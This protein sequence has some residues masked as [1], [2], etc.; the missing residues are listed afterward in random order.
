MVADE[1][2]I[3]NLDKR[4]V[5][6]EEEYGLDAALL[7]VSKRSGIL[8]GGEKSAMPVRGHEHMTWLVEDYLAVLCHP[9]P[10]SLLEEEDV[11]AVK[12]EPAV[13]LEARNRS[14]IVSLGRHHIER[15]GFPVLESLGQHLAG[16]EMEKR[17][18]R[19]RA[20]RIRTLRAFIPQPRSLASGNKQHTHA[21]GGKFLGACRN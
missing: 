17:L 8:E 13:L 7:H 11:L 2:L 16:M 9:R 14:L 6:L 15:N 18:V 5:H 1:R 12:T 20:D 4:I 3:R 21:P 19:Y 10:H